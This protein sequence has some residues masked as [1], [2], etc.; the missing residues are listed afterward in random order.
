[1]CDCDSHSSS[2]ERHPLSKRRGDNNADESPK[3]V[4]VT[5][6]WARYFYPE[7][8]SKLL[9]KKYI[10]FGSLVAFNYMVQFCC[11]VAACNFYSDISRHAACTMSDGT[12]LEGEEAS[13]VY[14]LAI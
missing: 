8:V 4:I 10:L 5:M 3:E 9:H 6:K 1:M 12:L 14:D 7:M 11:C 2:E 13:A